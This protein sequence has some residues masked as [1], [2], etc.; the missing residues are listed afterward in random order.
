[1]ECYKKISLILCGML[2]MLQQGCVT[3]TLDDCPDSVRYAISFNY[4][5]HT[6]TSNRPLNGGY[7]RF[8]DDVDKM[9]VYVFDATTSKCVFVDTV[10]LSAPFK[11]DYTYPIPLNVGEYD[12][13]AWGRGRTPGDAV[14]VSTAIVPSIIPGTTTID[15]ARLKIDENIC[16]GQLERIFYSEMKDVK[17][18]AFVSRVDTMPLMNITNQIRVIISD[19]RTT[20]MQDDLD[21][22]I[23]SNDGA[24]SFNSRSA[25]RDDSYGTGGYFRSGNNAPDL[26]GRVVGS[27]TY[28]PYK[29]YRTDSILIADPIISEPYTG[30]G[31]NPMFIV[32]LSKLRLVQDNADTYLLIN[33]E[34]NP[35]RINL[36][37]ILQK[38]IIDRGGSAPRVQ[39]Q[40]DRQHRWQIVFRITDTFAT[41]WIGVSEWHKVPQEGG[42]GNGWW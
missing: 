29:T 27:V 4:T 5:L 1:M 10:K 21:I 19:A 39:Y 3:N 15:E 30:S 11:E 18:P 14:K 12:I 23:V 16:N 38:D 22:S 28:L 7:D 25:A 26:D 24:Y 32:D 40:L 13:I 33:F 8:Y 2:I 37:D 6:E 20:K 41:A 36:I 9:F 34:G 42:T 17:I 35:H 31:N